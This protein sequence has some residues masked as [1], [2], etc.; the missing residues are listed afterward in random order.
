MWLCHIEIRGGRSPVASEARPY[1]Q[2][3]IGDRQFGRSVAGR[4]AYR[5]IPQRS[6]TTVFVKA[7]TRSN[8]FG[9][10]RD[11]SENETLPA[12]VLTT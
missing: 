7:T 10:P 9:L 6:S 1:S 11:V 3:V 2:A 8:V 12:C 4:G 5:S